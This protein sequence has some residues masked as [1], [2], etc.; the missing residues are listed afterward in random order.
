MYRG[1]F[2]EEL[3]TFNSLSRD[4]VTIRGFEEFPSRFGGFQLPLSGSR[5]S[6]NNIGCTRSSTF[7]LPLSGSHDDPS[8]SPLDDNVQERSS[9][10]QLPLSGSLPSRRY[11]LLCQ[12]S[13]TFQLPLS[14]SLY[15]R[16]RTSGE[17]EGIITFNSLSRDHDSVTID[18]NN[19]GFI[20]FNSLSRDHRL[21]EEGSLAL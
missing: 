11:A 7:Q 13:R 9:T 5:K 21:H 20:S 8:L 2:D 4:H 12:D 3:K 10:F 14:G 19:D 16:G 1:E 17:R 6:L 15:S 18:V